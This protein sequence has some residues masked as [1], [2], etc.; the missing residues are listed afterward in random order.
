MVLLHSYLLEYDA[1]TFNSFLETILASNSTTTSGAPRRNQSP[2]LFMDAAN[3]IFSEAKHRVFLGTISNQSAAQKGDERSNGT[4]GSNVATAI[5]VEAEEDAF[6]DEEEAMYGERAS[7]AKGDG[8][9]SRKKNWLPPGIEP[10]LEELPKWNLLREVLD[11]IEQEIHFTATDL[12]K[13]DTR[14]FFRTLLL[15]D[16]T[17][18]FSKPDR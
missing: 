1:V 7:A 9:R 17:C 6:A 4:K 14:C 11:E 16:A 10:V 3:T 18:S 13:Y 15:S 8:E 5:D 12:S 2:W